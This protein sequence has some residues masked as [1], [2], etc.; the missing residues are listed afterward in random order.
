V[1]GILLAGGAGTRLLPLTRSI[2]KQILPVYDKP[3]IYYPLST[4]MLAGVR[5]ILVISTPR[6]LPMIEALLGDGRDLGLAL[7]YAEQAAPRG[8][9]EALVIGEGFLAGGPVCLILG[10]NLFYGHELTDKLRAAAALERGARIF[11]YPVRDPERYG[12]VEV[13]DAGVAIGIEEKP[14]R[15]RSNLAVTG[16]YFF[17][18]RAAALARALVPSPRGELEITDLN[19]RYLALG[20]LSVTELGR[21][22]A[23]LD[24]GTFD[25]LLSAAGFVQTIQER[26][27]LRVACLEE[28]A[29]VMGYIGEAELAVLAARYGASDYGAYLRRVPELNR[30]RVP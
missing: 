6:D 2:S 10:D 7:S 16:L 22:V 15:P 17:D 5:E 11:A 19:A 3:T 25:S 27:G 18:G 12:V 23:W 29:F 13:D 1:K 28:I 30:R 8:I 9:A 26:Q 4:L 20:E 14:A 24:T 21:G